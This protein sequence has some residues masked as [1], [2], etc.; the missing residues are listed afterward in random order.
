MPESVQVYS[1]SNPDYTITIPIGNVANESTVLQ[2]NVTLASGRYSFRIFDEDFGWYNSSSIFLNVTKLNTT[3]YT[4]DQNITKT[5]FN[6]GTVKIIG[7]NIGD[8]ATISINGFKS[9]ILT[10][11][12]TYAIF[13]VP[14]LVTSVSQTE[15]NLIRNKTLDLSN[16]KKWG[17]SDGW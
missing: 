4:L 17:D 1:V 8:G 12:D 2:F 13:K 16:M 9:N 5:S 10:K 6:G 14:Q 11:T 15:F 3:T 7:D